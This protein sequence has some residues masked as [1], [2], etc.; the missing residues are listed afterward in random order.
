[1]KWFCHKGKKK[2]ICTPLK[3]R[4]SARTGRHFRAGRIETSS[5]FYV[6][7]LYS[8]K[9][10][11][12]YVG[13]TTNIG[14]RLNEH[15]NGKNTSTKAYLP[16]EVVYYESFDTRLGARRREKYLK[17]AAGRKWRKENIRPRG[18]TE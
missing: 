17:T 4:V 16:W 3:V 10:D 7:V 14:R 12:Y 1:M 18:A 15:N 8:E 11:R 13:L 6:Y 2:Y 5:I 9:N